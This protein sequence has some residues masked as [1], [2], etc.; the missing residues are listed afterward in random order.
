MDTLFRIGLS[1]ALGAAV[2]ALVAAGVARL[3]R[4][5]ATTHVLWVTVLLKLVTPP[6]F[7]IPVHLAQG[8][9]PAQRAGPAIRA[10]GSTPAAFNIPAIDEARPTRHGTFARYAAEAGMIAW[11]G[12]AV[13]LGAVAA[14]RLRRFSK[15]L[16]YARPA[17]VELQAQCRQLAAQLGVRRCP[18]VFLL[19][20]PV[21]PM[22][23]AP[24]FRPRLIIPADLWDR[25]SLRQ[26]AALLL[27]ELA[28]IKRT[29]H[30]VRVLEL[31]SLTL[32]WWHPA[33]W[34][35]RHELREAEEQC[36][37][38]WVTW[39]MPA[40]SQDYASALVEAVEFASRSNGLFPPPLPALASGM[41]EFRQ[42][43]RRLVM[44]QQGNGTRTLGP[45]GIAC[46]SAAALLL[47][48]TL[49]RA[50][51]SEHATPAAASQGPATQPGSE[52]DI[53]PVLHRQLDRQLPEL[54]FDG[55]GLSDVIDFLRDV[56]GANVFVN[57]K[58]LEAAGIDRNAPVTAR[59]RN[60]KFSKALSV[61]LDSAGGKMG[62]LNWAPDGNIIMI[63]AGSNKVEQRTYDVKDL[64]AA[65]GGKE[66]SLIRMITDSIDADSWTNN[67][68]KVGTI[69]IDHG[70]MVILQTE[71]NQKAIANLLARARELLKG[72]H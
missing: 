40:G 66:D 54:S 64:V 5:P 46:A 6:L 23:W 24:L 38:A 60:I 43:K 28:H 44:I 61:V 19:P 16:R 51:R 58:S 26:R 2:L 39:A 72:G 50:Q 31:I 18:Q 48:L 14:V 1:N 34:W 25:L 17:G 13:A 7:T 37:D 49:S 32:F 53:D 69:K 35:A 71:A 11:L 4:R 15:L 20:G 22:L 30:W 57:W 59:L 55:V 27:H 33:A 52:T 21:C 45:M 68:G 3:L 41:G 63:T 65:D 9:S 62:L 10:A 36:C 67:G 8:R 70:K 29:D 47:P 56:S 12:G 42:L